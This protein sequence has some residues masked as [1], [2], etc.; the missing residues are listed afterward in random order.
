MNT[1]MYEKSRFP[2][3]SRYSDD[4]QWSLWK[5]NKFTCGRSPTQ[6]AAIRSRWRWFRGRYKPQPQHR[7]W[8]TL[9]MECHLTR[10]GSEPHSSPYPIPPVSRHQQVRS[11]GDSRFPA[12]NLPHLLRQG[13]GAP[14]SSPSIAIR[15]RATPLCLIGYHKIWCDEER[16]LAY[17]GDLDGYVG[18][19]FSGVYPSQ[20]LQPKPISDHTV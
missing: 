10:L 8:R 15:L 13:G 1:T 6:L 20:R 18:M 3:C 16:C 9:G 5:L 4:R 11:T 2:G 19:T 12:P 7:H 17:L 14:P